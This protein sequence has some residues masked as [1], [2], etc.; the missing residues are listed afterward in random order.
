MI[1]FEGFKVP[2]SD[3]I[4]WQDVLHVEETE[5]GVNVRNHQMMIAAETMNEEI[6]HWC[7]AHHFRSS[8]PAANPRFYA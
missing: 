1:L 7:L 8:R 6:K 3:Q 4:L 5:Y 2:F